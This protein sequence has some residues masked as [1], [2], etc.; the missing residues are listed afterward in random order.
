MNEASVVARH[1]V[2]PEP[3]D[4]GAMEPV[5]AE[6][7]QF[8]RAS[9]WKL[10]WWKFRRHRLAVASALILLVFYSVVPFVEII[11]P[12]NQTKRHGDFLYAPPQPI[13]LF[14]EGRLVGPFVYP[15]HFEFNLETFRRDYTVD[16][17]TPQRVRFFCR[18]DTYEFWGVWTTDFTSCAHP[19]TARCSCSEPTDS[20]GTCSP[21]SST[22]RESP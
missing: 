4:P 16:R 18:A 19:R 17:S 20:D 11:A 6:N 22:G 21:A 1:Y 5:G 7:E 10:M 3:F 13:H 2:D 12:Y 9:S 14:H 8:Y 15:Y